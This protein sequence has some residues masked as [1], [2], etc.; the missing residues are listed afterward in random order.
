ALRPGPGFGCRSDP[1]P[2]RQ[3]QE[4]AGAAARGGA[5]QRYAGDRVPYGAPQ[6]TEQV[7]QGGAGEIRRPG[8]AVA[9]EGSGEGVRELAEA[10]ERRPESGVA[11]TPGAIG[12]MSP[13][14]LGASQSEV[15]GP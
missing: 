11:V 14:S 10:G 4:G 9:H 15:A 5:D 6:G 3:R 12:A 7:P 8:Q 2:A 13:W 1:A